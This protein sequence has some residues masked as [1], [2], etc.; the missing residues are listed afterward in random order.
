MHTSNTSKRSEA[1]PKR[2]DK[3]RSSPN[4]GAPPPDTFSVGEV[5]LD[6]FDPPALASSTD[7]Y[8]EQYARTR[9]ML[10]RIG[11][12]QATTVLK[13]TYDACASYINE[14]LATSGG[15]PNE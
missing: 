4:R 5:Y 10:D 13:A 1:T 6:T 7:A 14:V 3:P 11:W 15:Q 9:A 2:R 8:M 12:R